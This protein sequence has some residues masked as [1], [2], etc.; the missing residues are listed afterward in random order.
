[1][2]LLNT[3]HKDPSK[4]TEEALSIVYQLLRSGEPPNLET[5]QK[6]IDRIFFNPKKYDLGEVGRYRLNQQFNL[7][8]PVEDTVLTMDDI[9][10][11]LN[12]LINMR[13]GERG[14]DDIDHLGNRRVKSIGEQL[15]NQFSVALSRMLRTC[16]LYTSP[17]PRDRG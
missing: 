14:A 16:L 1:M 5:A 8:V 9:I 11:V 10:Q 6:F 13:K 7:E 15:T 12:F 17:S 3:M 2:M 4:N